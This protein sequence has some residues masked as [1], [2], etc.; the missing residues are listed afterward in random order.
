MN[1][2]EFEGKDLLKKYKI[3]TPAGVVIQREQADTIPADIAF[4]CV[5]KA[6]VQSGKRGKG[7]GVL[8]AQNIDE[9]KTHVADLFSKK[10]CNDTVL[11]VL[12]E[13]KK[14]IKQEYYLA[15]TYNTQKKI[16]VV[17]FSAQGGMDIE[18]DSENV[19]VLDID[20]LK[21]FEEFRMRELLVTAGARGKDVALIAD[22]A[23][24]LYRVFSG[25]DARLAEI[26]PLAKLEDGSFVALD[27]KIIL[28]EDAGFRHQWNKLGPR[29]TM[30]R[31][32]TQ[33]EQAVRQ[34]DAGE[35]Y[36][37][38][39]AGK[40]I[41]M[42]GDIACLFSGGG[43]SISM[44][45]ALLK[46]GGKPAN[47]T[48]YSGNPPREKVAALAKIVLSKP[49][50]RGIWIVG[51]VANFTHIGNTMAGIADVLRELKPTI[52]IIIRR[53]G[54][55]EAEG[56]KLMEKLAAELQLD[57]KWYGREISM[58]QTAEILMKKV[59]EQT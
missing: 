28:D 13:A 40:Y 8:F 17:L 39:T 45:D 53:A 48:E 56:R 47:Y 29:T 44:M 41:E 32:L 59:N 6:Q 24:R 9:L 16:P 14:A 57:L 55:H 38:G 10:I 52:P 34:V 31:L 1:L 43:A 25:E 12:V 21:G 11:Y 18:Q 22:T 54:P 49:G 35:F 37:R 26:N 33:R 7:G 4:P 36:Y 27:A 51:G 5:V 15:I 2:Y 58:T 30:G 3:P 42:D 20:P 50:L 19:H 23:K 46:V